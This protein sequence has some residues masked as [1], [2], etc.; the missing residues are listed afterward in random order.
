M[1][2]K[3]NVGVKKCVSGRNALSKRMTFR[4]LL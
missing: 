1:N 4:S 3:K 2:R